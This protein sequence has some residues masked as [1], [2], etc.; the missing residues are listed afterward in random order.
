MSYVRM[1][2]RV[3]FQMFLVTTLC[4]G[5]TQAQTAKEAADVEAEVA[6]FAGLWNGSFYQNSW[7]TNYPMILEI[8]PV[9]GRE[10]AVVME[11]TMFG[12]RTRTSGTGEVTPDCASWVELK[13]E[14]G[15]G[16]ELF[17]RYMAN[18]STNQSLAGK[19]YLESTL[20]EGGTFTLKRTN[21]EELNSF[22]AENAKPLERLHVAARNVEFLEP[23]WRKIVSSAVFWLDQKLG[24]DFKMIDETVLPDRQYAGDLA[25]ALERRRNLF[26]EKPGAE[27]PLAPNPSDD[28]SSIKTFVVSVPKDFL[29]D[30][31][32]YPLLIQLHGGGGGRRPVHFNASQ[33][34]GDSP[35]IMVKPISQSGWQAKALNYLLGEIKRL[36]PV[37]EDRVYLTGGSMGGFGTYNWAMANPEH[38]AAISPVCGGG[39]IFMAPRLKNLPIWIHH[40]EQD[41]SVPFW[42]AETMLLALQACGASVKHTFYPEG[43]HNLDPLIDRKALEQW[44]LEHKRSKGPT[45]PDLV[46]ELK[47]GADGLG[48][49]QQVT[50]P[51]Q[52]F[53]SIQIKDGQEYRSD[54][55]LYG[56]FKTGGRRAQGFLQHQKLPSLPEGMENL[57]LEIP[58]DLEV[59]NLEN[60]VKIVETPKCRAVSFAMI[61][62]GAKEEQALI[63]SVMKELEARGEI[64]TG[65]IRITSLT[66]YSAIWAGNTRRPVQRLEILLK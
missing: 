3:V 33:P 26:S 65:E 30:D 12:S 56:V 23:A 31:R 38:F 14:H 1:L 21:L 60:D 58:K 35:L 41:P 36:L 8:K 61:R 27:I 62:H 39:D 47:L 53:A 25:D 49:K 66:R 6:K 32:K 44:F 59:K 16:V 13:I 40:G 15:D 48:P 50:L 55:K 43:K 9:K 45:P 51:E 46:A 11:W 22:R 54:S 52:R 29:G 4:S 63:Q 28:P 5:Q 64:P 24:Y 10:I 7:K 19:C 34:S 2:V 57:I 20:E 17:G 18:L 42:F 37:D